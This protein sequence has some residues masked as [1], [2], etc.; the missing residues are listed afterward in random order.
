ML[1]RGIVYPLGGLLSLLVG[2]VIINAGLDVHSGEIFLWL[3]GI[4]GF[5]L[6]LP[7][8]LFV[9]SI[10]MLIGKLRYEESKIKNYTVIFTFLLGLSWM[11]LMV[12]GILKEI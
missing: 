9:R 2:L 7:I 6:V 4:F 12:M 8:I 5:L 1:K 11:T 3:V 10:Q